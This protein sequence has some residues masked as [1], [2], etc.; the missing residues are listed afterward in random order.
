MLLVGAALIG[1]A[2]VAAAPTV[3]APFPSFGLGPVTNASA[4][5]PTSSFVAIAPC[6]L[7]DTRSGVGFIRVS[8]TIIEVQVSERCGLPAE[9]VAAAFVVTA[10]IPRADGY[11]TV[12]PAHLP[13]VPTTSNVNTQAYQTRANGAVV[14]VSPGG[15]VRVHTP[16]PGDLVL[17]ATGGFV[18]ATQAA[19]GR[20]VAVGPLRAYD[21]RRVGSGAR[22]PA[23]STVLVPLPDGVPA[24]A[25]A[26]AVTLTAAEAVTPGY[27]TAFPADAAAGEASAAAR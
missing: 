22:V 5:L 11:V 6:R 3:T 19:A 8:P 24:D 17:D 26:L 21:S 25:S 14:Q 2:G 7:A 9:L 18:A 13:T 1:S 16:A 20:L 12:Y 10:V 27:A 15:A 4:A 23:G